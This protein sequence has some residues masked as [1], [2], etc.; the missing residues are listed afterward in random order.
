[1][2]GK[3]VNS[4]LVLAGQAH[5]REIITLEGIGKDGKLHP[6]QAAF[7]QAGAVQCGFCTPGAILSALYLLE[8]T[9]DPADDQI[10]QSLSGNLC[11]CT[12]YSK[13][14]AAV[15]LAAEEMRHDR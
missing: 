8:Q 14:I 9:P 7:M 4:C 13:M 12:G 6:L 1:M 10:R 15:R 3:P 2:D 5:Q 11:R